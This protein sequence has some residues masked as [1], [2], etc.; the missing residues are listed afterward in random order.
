M[1]EKTANSLLLSKHS[2]QFS[3]LFLLLSDF[4]VDLTFTDLQ[5]CRYKIENIKNLNQQK[6]SLKL[7]F[8]NENKNQ[9]DSIDLHF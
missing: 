7:T 5:T 3:I 9:K 4:Y 6:R 2:I 1:I 8:L